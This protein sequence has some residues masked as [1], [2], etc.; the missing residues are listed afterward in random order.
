MTTF[1]DPPKESFRPSM[2]LSDTRYRSITF[3]VIA[4]ALLVTAIWYL[5]SNLAANLRA[6][7]LNISFQ[8][9][10]NPAGYDI[11]QTL[12]PYTS[13]SSNLQAAWVGIINTLLV[14][15]LACV[16]A[17]IF[18]VIAGVLRLSNNWLIRKQMWA[19]E[20]PEAFY[21]GPVDYAWQKAQQKREA[22]QPLGALHLHYSPRV[23]AALSRAR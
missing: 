7:G 15:F 17:T 18:G 11:N 14:S 22:G 8:F 20:A 1:S 13:Q 3:Q 21:D 19:I 23:A 6:A 12:I 5:G 2:L 16:T 9:L 10:G 4:L